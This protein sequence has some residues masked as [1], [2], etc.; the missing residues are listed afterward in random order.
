M[1]NF[2]IVQPENK[3]DDVEVKLINAYINHLCIDE[4]IQNEVIDIVEWKAIDTEKFEYTFILKKMALTFI[5]FVNF[6]ILKNQMSVQEGLGFVSRIHK[7]VQTE[8]NFYGEIRPLHFLIALPMIDFTDQLLSFLTIELI[9]FSSSDVFNSKCN[10]TLL[11]G[12]RENIS[13]AFKAES[14][15]GDDIELLTHQLQNSSFTFTDQSK[16]SS[17]YTTA[18]ETLMKIECKRKNY[19]LNFPN[20]IFTVVLLIGKMIVPPLILT[21]IIVIINLNFLHT[22]IL[23]NTIGEIIKDI[24]KL[25]TCTLM[26]WLS[27]RILR[28]VIFFVFSTLNYDQN[29]SSNTSRTKILVWAILPSYIAFM[30]LMFLMLYNPY[31]LFH[32][33][34]LLLLIIFSKTHLYFE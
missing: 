25:V 16:S 15:I 4:K 30:I 13:T 22:C 5:S 10:L 17:L 31:T 27:I 34:L 26:F 18:T 11:Q 21:L 7:W 19:D 20:S 14:T 23:D 32:A 6:V 33:R 29:D 9:D 12:R 1:R 2:V 28:F 3:E 24:Y 8:K